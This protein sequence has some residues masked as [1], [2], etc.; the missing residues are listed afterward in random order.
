[1]SGIRRNP[2][3]IQR[4]QSDESII[5]IRNAVDR[6]GRPRDWWWPHLRL[7]W[8]VNR[9]EINF[10]SIKFL[11][12]WKSFFNNPFLLKGSTSVL[13][14]SESPIDVDH[15]VDPGCYSRLINY[16]ASIKQMK[17][18]AELSSECHQSIKVFCFNLI[19]V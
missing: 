12:K 16:N 2:Q 5:C 6:S 4:T 18:L 13:H 1:M 17:T 7:L 15:C 11:F 14:V 8:Y 10:I 9:L 3:D 19:D